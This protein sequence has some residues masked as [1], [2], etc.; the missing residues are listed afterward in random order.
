MVKELSCVEIIEP[1]TPSFRRRGLKP[2]DVLKRSPRSDHGFSGRV[3][4]FNFGEDPVQL[5]LV[6]EFEQSCRDLKLP[7]NRAGYSDASFVYGVQ[8]AN[9]DQVE[10]LSSLVSVRSI[11]GMPLVRTLRP[12][13]LNPRPLPPLATHPLVAVHRTKPLGRF[14]RNLVLLQAFQDGM[15]HR[16]SHVGYTVNQDC[17]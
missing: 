17:G 9:E 10:A 3:R 2:H 1:I 15:S 8:F 7:I 14:R 5:G 16:A 12:S 6:R 11:A 4:L 13:N